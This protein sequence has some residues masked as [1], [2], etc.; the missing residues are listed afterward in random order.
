MAIITSN[1]L[2]WGLFSATTSWTGWI[3]PVLW[4]KVTINAWDTIEVDWIHSWGNDTTTAVI[5]NWTLKASRLVSSSLTTRWNMIVYNTWWIDYWTPLSPIPVNVNAKLVTNDSI[6]LIEWKYWI[7]LYE[8]AKF[9]FFWWYKNINTESTTRIITGSTTLTVLDATGWVVWDVI[10]VAT[11]KNWADNYAL[12]KTED[13]IITAIVW[14]VITVWVAFVN[15]HEIWARVWNFTNNVMITWATNLAYWYLKV[16]QR[17]NTPAL[18]RHIENTAFQYM[19]S[20]RYGWAFTI[21][22]YWA[23]TQEVYSWINNITFFWWSYYCMDLYYTYAKNKISNIWV[24][25]RNWNWIAIRQWSSAIIDNYVCYTVKYAGIYSYFNEWWLWVTINN[26][27]IIWCQDWMK[28][29]IWQWFVLNNVNIASC[30]YAVNIWWGKQITFNNCSIWYIKWTYI[31]RCMYPINTE[32]AWLTTALFNDCYVNTV[33]PT[34]V[35]INRSSDWNEIIFANKNVD[36]LQQEIYLSTWNMI[37][38]NVLFKTWISSMRFNPVNATIPLVNTWDI[39][40]PNDALVVVSW[41]IRKNASYWATNLPTIK[42]SW[43]WITTS[44]YTMSNVNDVW[45]Q[46]IVKWTQITWND[47]TLKLEVSGQSWTAWASFWVDWIVAP[48]SVPVNSWDFSY[49]AWWV[50]AK[51]LASNFTSWKDVWWALVS[52]SQ[53]AWSMWELLSDWFYFN[54][55]W[56]DEHMDWWWQ[57]ISL[58][59]TPWK[60]I[61][62]HVCRSDTPWTI[63]NTWNMTESIPWVYTYYI[64][65]FWLWATNGYHLVVANAWIQTASIIIDVH[66]KSNEQKVWEYTKNNPIAWSMWESVSSA[67]T[68]DDFL[69]LK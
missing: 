63:M 54:N 67:F 17:I 53:L 20:R 9:N 34:I 39:F 21:V 45:E 50:P 18:Y 30:N 5:V 7:T 27:W 60:T 43:L 42:L 38:D 11:T 69:A 15:I 37:R 22:S 12:N 4:D 48:A 3:V 25:I 29:T 59:A 61:T 14:N 47:W 8:L 23:S 66:S 1:W 58:T 16:I 26:S 19:W 62:I 32:I 10:V 6:A 49:W 40:A 64:N 41:Y 2:W 31:W 44:T 13:R 33:I 35:N 51:L 52:D 24:Y 68:T 56:P 57:T 36:P 46:F 65:W 55:I 28:Y